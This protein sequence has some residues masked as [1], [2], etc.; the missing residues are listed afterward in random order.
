MRG[1]LEVGGRSVAR[2]LG[3]AG[4]LS[5]Q[6]R[7]AAWLRGDPYTGR[8]LR[9]DL[10]L[11]NALDKRCANFLSRYKTF[12]LNPGRDFILRFDWAL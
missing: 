1:L 4:H 7:R 10:Q 3:G 12:A 11:R 5:L 6:D 9:V 8:G 2:R